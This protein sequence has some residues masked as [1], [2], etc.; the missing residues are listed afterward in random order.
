M[1]KWFKVGT[2][3]NL[4]EGVKLCY[5]KEW[6]DK[7]VRGWKEQKEGSADVRNKDGDANCVKKKRLCKDEVE[8]EQVLRQLEEEKRESMAQKVNRSSERKT[9]RRGRKNKKESL[10]RLSASISKIR[11]PYMIFFLYYR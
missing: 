5:C 7:K 3:L 9:V 6:K 11:T 2:I 8:K 1:I 4:D 10:R